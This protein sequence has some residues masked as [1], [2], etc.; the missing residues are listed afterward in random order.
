[1]EKIFKITVFLF[2]KTRF[3]GILML[4]YSRKVGAY[5]NSAER[6]IKKFGGQS[7]LASLIGKRQST[8]QYWAKSGL[9]PIKWHSELLKL[10]S[11]RGISLTPSDFL[12][13]PEETGIVAQDATSII[14]NADWFGTLSLG[15]DAG[16]PCYVLNDG[17]R[18]ISRAGATSVLTDKKGGGNLESYTK[19]E[20]LK[21]Y[22]PKEI[23]MIEFTLEG[24]VNRK[25]MGIEAETFLDIC[26]AYV[27]AWQNDVTT[28]RQTEIAKKASMF[29]AACAKVG[30]IALIDEATGYQYLREGDAL[31][32]KLKLYLEEEMRKWEKTF[33]DELWQEFGRLTHWT[34]SVTQRPKYWGKLVMELVYGYLDK[35]VA[36]WL[37]THAPQPKHGQN[38]HQWL[39]SQYGLKK[40]V[41]HLWLLIGLSKACHDMTELRDRTAILFGKHMVQLRLPFPYVPLP[42]ENI[43]LAKLN[44]Q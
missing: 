32:F 23:P 22:L 38:Y 8:V 19:V 37:K 33:P 43:R 1:M 40:L 44:K 18:V 36:E 20:S 27:L 5:M 7:V 41:E 35:D 4:V 6:I 14:P 16:L 31:Q 11:E 29:L 24:V 10:A 12:P 34:G 13:T 26:R 39:S 9:V 21:S 17:R 28:E 30:L 3:S 15:D 2:D 25:V 42:G